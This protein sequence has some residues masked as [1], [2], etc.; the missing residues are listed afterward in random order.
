MATDAKSGSHYNMGGAAFVG[1]W[2]DVEG[3]GVGFVVEFLKVKSKFTTSKHSVDFSR[4]PQTPPQYRS[5]P[6][7]LVLR[8]RKSGMWGGSNKG[9]EFEMCSEEVAASYTECRN[10]GF[11]TLTEYNECRAAGFTDKSAYEKC[12]R[13]GFASKAALDAAAKVGA[14]TKAEMDTIQKKGFSSRSEYDACTQMGFNSKADYDKCR[15]MGFNDKRDFDL[16]ISMGFDNKQQYEHC[17]QLGL[18]SKKEYNSVRKNMTPQGNPVAEAPVAEA[19]VTEAPVAEASADEDAN[20]EQLH[21][22]VHDAIIDLE[23]SEDEVMQLTAEF[24]NEDGHI[25]LEAFLQRLKD[26][27]Q[28]ATQAEVPESSVSAPSN[29][30]EPPG[31][32]AISVG[33][34]YESTASKV[35]SPPPD[36][37]EPPKPHETLNPEP[38]ADTPSSG[39]ASELNPKS[40]VQIRKEALEIAQQQQ[41]E[42]TA[43]TQHDRGDAEQTFR[44]AGWDYRI[45][46]PAFNAF[47]FLPTPLPVRPRGEANPEEE[48]EQEE[49]ELRYE[50]PDGV[51]VLLCIRDRYGNYRGYISDD[52]ECVNNRDNTIGWINRDD[53]TA[54]SVQEEYLGTCIDQLSGDECVVEDALDERCGSIN[55]GTASIHNNFGSTVAE[56]EA[57]GNV[58]GN[59]G[60]T[61]GQF[62][63]FSYPEIRT[64][65][66]YLMLID[67]G[68]LNEVEG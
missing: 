53:G 17:L 5:S 50:P 68:M 35:L 56:F 32:G 45:D 12:R 51:D 58:V 33:G 61:L 54:G 28:K 21:A 22:E 9:T 67:P 60:S 63:G 8:R 16:C 48:E 26:M 2:I 64:V 37:P 10:Q 55:L 59:H 46:G 6:Q 49:H 43:A 14:S 38:P 4:C 30:A 13:K 20:T 31:G 41:S 11:P 65:A 29:E 25:E 34:K 18:K 66:L 42:S 62:E 19:P 24:E 1:K 7:E 44:G 57:S 52:G 27:Q 47:A 40:E 36:L 3:Y 23:L 15:S 39:V